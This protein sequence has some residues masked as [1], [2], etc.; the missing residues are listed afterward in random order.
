MAHLAH[1]RIE[2]ARPVGAELPDANGLR[3]L[4]ERSAA[5]DQRAFAD[6]YDTTSELCFGLALSI[7][8][9]Q[10]DAERV[11]REAYLHLWTH[12]PD[13][14]AAGCDPLSSITGLV[15]RRAVAHLRLNDQV[16][17]EVTVWTGAGDVHSALVA[18]PPIQRE[19]LE[20]AYFGGLSCS[21]VARH[22][23]VTAAT[24]AD[25]IRDGVLAFSRGLAA[26][27]VPGEMRGPGRRSVGMIVWGEADGEPDSRAAEDE[28][29]DAD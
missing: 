4:L 8:H 25:R 2:H 13:Y 28:T 19:A 29:A 16:P 23:R 15:H 7:L 27:G 6:L 21:E 26:K 18:V 9:D 20:L 17:A 22:A 12:P 10:A 5:G 14:D 24:A 3:R 11:T 1:L